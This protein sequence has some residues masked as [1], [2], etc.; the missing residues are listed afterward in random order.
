MNADARRESV[1]ANGQQGGASSLAAPSPEIPR[2]IMGLEGFGSP[3]GADGDPAVPDRDFMVLTKETTLHPVLEDVFEEAGSG[4][5]RVQVPAAAHDDFVD[6]AR[7]QPGL[8]PF[9]RT[10]DHVGTVT[11]GFAGA[12]FDIALRGGPR[13]LLGEV[14]APT[15]VTVAV[16]P[17]RPR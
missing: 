12:F 16:Y 4:T 1:G 17:L 7:F 13:T 8:W 2:A 11:C 5:Y 10:A 14:P 6:S 9:P 15:D 3:F